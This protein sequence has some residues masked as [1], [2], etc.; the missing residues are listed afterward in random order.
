MTKKQNKRLTNQIR[1]TNLKPSYKET[2]KKQ[3]PNYT[4]KTKAK[5]HI[6]TKA[7]LQ[8]R[9]NHTQKNKGKTIQRKHK[10]HKNRKPRIA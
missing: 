3:R 10:K 5:L 6:K 4:K 7:K 1:T 2:H 8:K 9:Q